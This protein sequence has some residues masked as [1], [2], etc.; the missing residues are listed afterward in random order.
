M[1]ESQAPDLSEVVARAEAF[2]NS[3]FI[4]PHRT[5]PLPKREGNGRNCGKG[6]AFEWLCQHVSY[7]EKKCLFWPFSKSNGR[8]GLVGYRGRAFRPVR[9][10][11]M[12]VH[13]APPTARHLAAHTCG[14]SKSG[15]INPKHLAWKTASEAM[16]DE[17]REGRRISYGKCGKLLSSE[18]A[19]IRGLGGS[20][21]ATEI[22]RIYG[23]SGQRIGDILRGTAYAARR[24]FNL[25]NGRFYPKF[26]AAKRVYSLG[27]FASREDAAAA[28]DSARMRARLGEPILL[29]A[30]EKPT[31]DD[32]RRWYKPPL[33]QLKFGDREGELVV[34]VDANQEHSA[35]LL[36]KNLAKL[37][38]KVRTLI[39]AA[40][41]TGDLQEAASIAGLTAEQVALVLPSIRAYLVRELQHT[42][43][44][45]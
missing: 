5:G 28:Y 21:T 31:E 8:P 18:V 10:M 37:H 34:G 19:E 29:R 20:K 15:C 9:L 40:S 43:M 17:F 35:F 22:G 27:G 7:D 3:G 2:L 23:L 36:H 26:A 45:A 14:G 12:L 6:R 41:E 42:N 24:T 44:S 4:K 30:K 39:I 38:P 25:R 11:C 13:G 16:Y 1:S 33:Q 32:I